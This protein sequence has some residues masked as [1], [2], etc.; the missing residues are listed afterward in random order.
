M[1][2]CIYPKSIWLGIEAKLSRL[3]QSDEQVRFY[4]RM[5]LQWY[6]DIALDPAG[7]ILLPKNLKDYAE[8]HDRALVIGVMDHIELWKPLKFSEYA[9]KKGTYESA[10]KDIIAKAA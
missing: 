7:R 5:L 9:A 1:C 10:L 8:I 2:I 6:E 3:S 4:L